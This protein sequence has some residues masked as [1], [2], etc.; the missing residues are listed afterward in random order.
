MTGSRNFS[1]IKA[2]LLKSL[3]KSPKHN[4][5][6]LFTPHPILPVFSLLS[7]YWLAVHHILYIGWLFTKLSTL[8]LYTTYSLFTPPL[9]LPTCSLYFYI[10]CLFTTDTSTRSPHSAVLLTSAQSTPDPPNTQSVLTPVPFFW[11]VY[12]RCAQLGNNTIWSLLGIG[13]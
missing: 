3:Y 4:I 1:K 10:G 2:Q 11:H 13:S 9:K 8:P 7:L 12:T 6:L 5:L